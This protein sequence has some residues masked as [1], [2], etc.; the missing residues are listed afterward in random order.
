MAKDNKAKKDNEKPGINWKIAADRLTIGE[1]VELKTLP[2]YWV[3]PRK[4][5][6]AAEAQ[7]ITVEARAQMKKTS[8]RRTILEGARANEKANEK[9]DIEKMSGEVSDEL[10]EKVIEAVIENMT[11][12][13]FADTET[14]VVKLAYGVH[15]HNFFGESQGGS[16]E[17]A[18][19]L[20]EYK[21][22][23]NEILGI[24]EDKNSPLPPQTPPSS[25]T[26]PIGSSTAASSAKVAETST[27]STP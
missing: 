27:G 14:Q 23:F 12:E 3:Q 10:K 25:G 24:V 20:L 19:S 26:S 13:D 17:W 22:I 18:R 6:K 5:S 7:M 8:V 16:L 15:A 21:D 4:F 9:S 2:G 1:K 11:P